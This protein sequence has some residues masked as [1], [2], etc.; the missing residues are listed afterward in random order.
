MFLCTLQKGRIQ[1]H[2][3]EFVEAKQSYQNAV[4]INPCHIKSL[5]RLV[6]LDS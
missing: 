3:N 6:G 2:K 1:E 5:Q 4:S